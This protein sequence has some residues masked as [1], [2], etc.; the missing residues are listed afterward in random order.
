MESMASAHPRFSF[1]FLAAHLSNLQQ[2]QQAIDW[3]ERNQMIANPNKFHAV[4][5]TK[6]RDNTTGE[7]LM[8]QG[9]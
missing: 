7:K 2:N 5:V 6:G 3:L 8:I 4:L 1:Q 9:Q